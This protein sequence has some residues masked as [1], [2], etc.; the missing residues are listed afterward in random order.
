M[1][2]FLEKNALFEE[3]KSLYDSGDMYHALKI[4]EK[5]VTDFPGDFFAQS[6]LGLTLMAYARFEQ[7]IFRFNIAKERIGTVGD[8]KGV[9]LNLALSYQGLGEQQLAEA[10]PLFGAEKE[11][12]LLAAANNFRKSA[13]NFYDLYKKR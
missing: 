4:F 10:K 13:E 2:S 5:V 9:F 3:G 8:L 6:Y 1:I 11:R 7:A 12:L